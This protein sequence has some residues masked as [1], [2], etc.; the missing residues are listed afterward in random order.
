[1]HHTIEVLLYLFDVFLCSCES[2]HEDVE[3]FVEA[4]DF[5]SCVSS[6]IIIKHHLRFL[7][8]SFFF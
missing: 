7:G 2:L 8:I 3:L 6:A 1:M 5:Y 4:D